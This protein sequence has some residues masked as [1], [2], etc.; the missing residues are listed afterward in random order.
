METRLRPKAGDLAVDMGCGDMPYRALI[1]ARGARYVGCDIDPTAPVQIT[2]GVPISLDD[3]VRRRRRRRFRY[4]STSGIWAGISGECRR[5]LRPDGWLLLSTHGTWLYH[6]HPTDFRRWTRD[7]LVKEIE[8]HGFTVE[9]ITGIMGPLAWTT[10]FRLLG[11]REVL[12]RIPLFGALVLPFLISADERPN[13]SSKMPS[14][15]RRSGR[16]TPAF[17]SWWLVPAATTGA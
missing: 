8:G 11:Y 2:P 10:Q 5:M 6:P 15:R 17:T 12:R 14:H 3:A 4:S 16:P 7:G 13:G 9:R 1:E